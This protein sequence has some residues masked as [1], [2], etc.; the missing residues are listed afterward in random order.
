MKLEL[1]PEVEEKIPKGYKIDL[2]SYLIM[3][4][5]AK[6]VNMEGENFEFKLKIHPRADLP[7]LDPKHELHECYKFLKQND[8]YAVYNTNIEMI[9][10]P[11]RE[12]FQGTSVTD[13]KDEVD[14]HSNMYNIVQGYSDSD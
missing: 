14:T 11:L 2:K 10:E 5:T 4:Y 6:I 13:K 7:F 12:L 3:E 1:A 8:K 9:P